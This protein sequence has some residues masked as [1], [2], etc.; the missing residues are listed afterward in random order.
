MDTR[1]KPC[2]RTCYRARTLAAAAL[3]LLAGLSQAPA[4]VRWASGAPSA[5][6]ESASLPTVLASHASADGHLLVQLTRPITD[7]GRTQLA[8]EGLTVQ[9]PLGNLSFFASMNAGAD[10]S[11]LLSSDWLAGASA[12]DPAWKLHR[13]FVNGVTAI[14][15]IVEHGDDPHVAVYVTLHDDVPTDTAGQLFA[16]H[17]GALV[18]TMRS[19]NA[20]VVHLPRSRILTL[21]TEDAVQ[22]IEPAAPKFDEQ[23][24]ESRALTG[25]GVVQASPY[26]LTGEG[27]T[28]LVFDVGSVRTTHLDLAGRTTII[29]GNPLTSGH[30]THVAGS[31][32]GTGA[33]SGGTNRGMAP[34]VTLLS[35]TLTIDGI[36]GWLYTNPCDIEADYAAAWDLGADL[37]TNSISTNVAANNFDCGWYGDYGTT[38]AV[39]D[40]LIRGGSP[41]TGGNPFRVAW[42]AGNERALQR[43]A[44][45]TGFFY[46]APPAGAKNQLCIG[47]VNSDSDT[48]S[49]Y[50]S[51]GPTDDGRMRPDFCAPGCQ[52]GGDTGVTSCDNTSDSAYSVRCGTSMATPIAAGCVA[53]LMQD[54]RA[55]YPADFDPRNSLLKVC[56]A[57][58]AIDRGNPGPDYSYGYGSIRVQRAIDLMRSG[59]FQESRVSQD[60]VVIYEVA[61]PA[62]QTELAVTMAWDD[63]PAVGNAN[64]ALINDLDLEVFSPGN[65][66]RA[67]PWTLDMT[68]P[69]ADAQRTQA[70]RIDNIEQV[71]VENP[72]AGVWAVRVRGFN[73]PVGPQPFSIVSSHALSGGAPIPSVL[74][75]A[76]QVVLDHPPATPA[77][78][79]ISIEVRNDS[80][81]AGSVQLRYREGGLGSWISVPMTN[82]TGNTWA[83]PLPG[84][85]CDSHPQY[86]F[87]A[88]GNAFGVATL[89]AAGENSPFD[90]D[91]GV[92]EHLYDH[93]FET[94]AGWIGGRPGDTA[95]AGVWYRMAPQATAAQ[96]G[97]DHSP[98]PGALCWVTDGNAGAGV[99]ALD[100]D[101]GFTTLLS[102]ALDL[103]DEPDA[104]ISYWRW[105]SNTA[106]ASPAS[107]TM[108]IDI[109][110]DDGA[111]WSPLEVVGPSTQNSGGWLFASFRLGDFISPTSTVRLRFIADD[112]GGPSVVEA[113]LDDF[114]I[115]KRVCE[116]PAVCDPDVN[117]DG[118]VNGFDIEATEQAVN[119]DFTNFC[120]SSA[121]L[122]NDG[123]ENGFDIEIEEQ[124]VNGAPC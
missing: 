87:M 31:V 20:A 46:L 37:A 99:G 124:R 120:Q 102:P 16:R 119:G 43:C 40:S 100:V 7:A 38:A 113:A 47:S 15:T 103:A 116:D 6:L 78:A 22:W 73:V 9:A 44:T 88:E 98:D 96:P 3:S 122:N 19:V 117:C 75:I 1:S 8:G 63:A 52:A 77:I 18:G 121:D 76:D 62:G 111:S 14:W 60:Q 85:S 108:R 66:P 71:R 81:V 114:V 86:Y 95:T 12:I 21:A 106:G 4:Q 49:S 84:F 36:P 11:G 57:Q 107:D 42:A 32:G 24:A 2:L 82:S 45:P 94:A 61:V 25:A 54:F 29:D 92:T 105:Y 59:N 23:N 112:S 50:S 83:A 53:L 101:G 17:A 55:R 72:A 123:A 90:L 79:S 34:D 110:G 69:A 109:S 58:S 64:P 28:V 93:D 56:F 13:D 104:V 97:Q 89:P 33:A 51:I 80:L 41:V 74:M 91:I 48:L 68:N 70:N 30:A 39:I 67:F 5:A 118:A 26:S 27:V 115:A 35:G 65:G 10:V